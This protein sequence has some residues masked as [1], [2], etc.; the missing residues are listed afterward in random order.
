M[1]ESKRRP[2]LA[3]P[4]IVRLSK[5]LLHFC[6]CPG[7]VILLAIPDAD[8]MHMRIVDLLQCGEVFSIPVVGNMTVWE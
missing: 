4:D 5:S 2:A 1:A 3:N 8:P 7:F 6:S